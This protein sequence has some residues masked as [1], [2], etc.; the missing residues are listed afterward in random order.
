MKEIGCGR[1]RG[2]LARR[3]HVSANYEDAS[4]GL[5]KGRAAMARWRAGCPRSRQW[6]TRGLG[7]LLTNV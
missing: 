2:H 1:E 6:G 5:L 4:C 7:A 3:E